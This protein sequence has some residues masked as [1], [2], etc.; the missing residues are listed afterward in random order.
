M[1]GNAAGEHPTEKSLRGSSLALRVPS[2]FLVQRCIRRN[3]SV[4]P[5]NATLGVRPRGPYS[6]HRTLHGLRREHTAARCSRRVERGSDV[7]TQCRI[8]ERVGYML[9]P[10]RT[11]WDPQRSSAADGS[12]DDHVAAAAPAASRGSVRRRLFSHVSAPRGS[13]LY[14][15]G[16]SGLDTFSRAAE[17]LLFLLLFTHLRD[18]ARRKV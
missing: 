10:F 7:K 9:T 16:I 15:W 5:V 11:V 12:A 1:N 4:Q 2:A 14:R 8:S 6:G 17:V 3:I 13:I 18:D